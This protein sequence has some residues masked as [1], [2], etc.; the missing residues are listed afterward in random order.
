MVTGRRKTVAVLGGGVAGLTAAHELNRCGYDVAV[1]ESTGCRAQDLGGKARSFTGPTHRAGH[2]MFGEHGFRFF[3]GFY[4]HVIETMETI[5][6]P[7]VEEHVVDNL[8]SLPTSMFYARLPDGFQEGAPTTTSPIAR[9][10]AWIS[11]L[12]V[13]VFLGWLIF[14]C[15]VVWY[16]AMPPLAWVLWLAGPIAWFL[17]RTVVFVSTEPG[18][19]WLAIPLPPDGTTRPHRVQGWLLRLHGWWRYLAVVLALAPLRVV[20]DPARAVPLVL[21]FIGLAWWYPALATVRFLWG[22]ILHKIPPGVRPGALESAAA[23]LRI[24]AVITASERRKYSQWERESW[25]SFIGA[26]RYSRPFQLA[27]ATG[28]TRSFVA[29][30]AE[31]MSARTGAS[32]LA[33]LLYDISPTLLDRNPADRVLNGPTHEAWI[34]PWVR[35]LRDDGVR[36]NEF[37]VNS[38]LIPVSRV[39]VTELCLREPHDVK[40]PR[41][42]G[43]TY[44]GPGSEIPELAPEEFDYY[45]LAVSGTAAQRILANSDELIRADRDVS[46]LKP[47][48][49][50]VGVRPDRRSRIEKGPACVKND[51]D[52]P[53]LDGIFSLD[54]GWMT[55]LVYHLEQEVELPKAH[56]LCLESEWALTAID[57]GQVWGKRRISPWQS[58]ISV[59]VSDWFSPSAEA[60]PARFESLDNVRKETWRQLQAHVPELRRIDGVP[61]FV[62]D[63]AINDPDP[64]ALVERMHHLVGPTSA[65]ATLENLALTN[66]ETLLVNTVGSWDNRPTAQ[67][68]FANLVIAGDY[69]RTWTDFASME[70]ANEAAKHAVNVIL[71][72]DENS[73]APCKVQPLKVPREL[74]GPVRCVSA[75]DWCAVR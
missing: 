3:P 55:G 39:E 10:K 26:Y 36:F 25:W 24:A 12:G 61:P 59:N 54:F 46:D 1:F 2:P 28:L 66:N 53:Y 56:L 57:V 68:A 34:T 18:C 6:L 62:P 43:F 69:V 20:G 15:A 22:S 8:V 48:A 50:Q 35:K 7:D 65:T 51:R 63:K 30:R 9:A 4:S 17:V 38:E 58:V 60:L 74:K 42:G 32:I 5:P 49:E 73:A 75:L 45:V 64:V 47:V 37:R 52:L 40:A 27:F 72:H 67:T 29:T 33:Q 31:R 11:G 16:R 70:S 13:Y 44:L 14:G 19:T 71:A 41:V 23:S 21:L